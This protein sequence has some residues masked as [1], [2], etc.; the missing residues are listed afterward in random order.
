MSGRVDSVKDF[1]SD[2]MGINAYFLLELK[3]GKGH[4]K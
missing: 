3:T 4:L 2:G 1:P